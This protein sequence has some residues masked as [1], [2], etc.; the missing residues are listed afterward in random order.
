ML[1]LGCDFR[2]D[3][4]CYFSLRA[5]NSE[6]YLNDAQQIRRDSVESSQY[7]E[8]G[9]VTVSSDGLLHPDSACFSSCI[10]PEGIS[11]DSASPTD[12]K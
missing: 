5:Y 6:D 12:W 2:Q 8:I 9:E 1:A 10:P 4:L 7:L 3:G 11:V